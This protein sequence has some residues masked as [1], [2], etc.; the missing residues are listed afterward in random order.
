MSSGLEGRAGGE[1][2]TLGK[3]LE[4]VRAWRP[5]R[6]SQ[7]MATQFLPAMAT[8]APPSRVCEHSSVGCRDSCSWNL[9]TY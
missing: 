9:Q 8:Q 2:G 3:L 6:R 4:T 1:I 7:A 5:R